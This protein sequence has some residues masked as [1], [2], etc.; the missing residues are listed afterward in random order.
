MLALLLLG[1]VAQQATHREGIAGLLPLA[2][3]QFQFQ[4]AAVGSVVAQ[5]SAV[6]LLAIQ[7]AADERGHFS[8]AL[9]TNRSSNESRARSPALSSPK[10]RFQAGLA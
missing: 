3:A 10:H 5:W 7:G 2:Q 8:A 1:Y 6:N 4:Y 9:G